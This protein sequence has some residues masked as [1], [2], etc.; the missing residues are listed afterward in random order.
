MR[1]DAGFDLKAAEKRAATIAGALSVVCRKLAELKPQLKALREDFKKKPKGTKIA[2]CRTWTDFCQKQLHRTDRAVQKLLAYKATPTKPK[3]SK[4]R[5][6]Q[7]SGSEK[8]TPVARD[9]PTVRKDVEERLYKELKPYADDAPL[10]FKSELLELFNTVAER[11][12][13]EVRIKPKTTTPPPVAH[14][15]QPVISSG[16]DCATG[17]A[18]QIAE[19][20]AA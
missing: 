10:S 14:P 7:S 18:V 1:E 19:R 3:P 6:E 13:I 17:S 5:P 15:H 9:W 2:G 4:P 20:R 16:N 8:N 11:F 12:G